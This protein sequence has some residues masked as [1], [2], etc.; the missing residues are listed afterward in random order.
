[1]GRKKPNKFFVSALARMR[2]FG[3][4]IAAF[5][6]IFLSYA[7]WAASPGAPGDLYVSGGQAN[8]ILQFDGIT[9]ASAGTFVPAGSGGMGTPVGVAWGPNGNLFVSSYNNDA[10]LQF[11]GN[12]GVFIN[13][14]ATG[15]GLDGPY[16]LTFGPDGNLY[17]CSFLNAR[18]VKFNGTTGAALGAFAT[19]GTLNFPAD[20]T[21]GPNGHLFVTS[22]TN[23]RVIQFDGTS[24]AVIGTFASG[25]G[26][27]SATG[28]TFGP[29]GNLFVASYNNDQVIQYDGATGAV[30]GS[31]AS[32]GGLDGTFGIEFG[33]D[34]N[35]YVAGYLSNNVV[36]YNGG[37]GALMG[38]F[39]TGVGKASFVKFKPI[40][41]GFPSP[42]VT[43]F[44]PASSM[45]CADI[46]ATIDGSG[47][48]TGLQVLL[49][50]AGQP[51]I[52][53]SIVTLSPT[54]VTANFNL[55]GVAL[56]SW[57]VETRYPDEQSDTLAAALDVTQCPP[58]SVTDF[59]P[60]LANNC[61]PLIGVTIIGNEFLT[62]ATVKLSRSGQSDIIGTSVVVQDQY[63]ITA[64]FN[65]TGAA[66][67]SWNLS[68]TNPAQTPSTLADALEII[69]CPPPVVSGI[70]PNSTG[71]C[72]VLNGATINGSNFLAGATVKLSMVGQSDIN[73]TGV[74]IGG[75]GTTIMANFAITG[76]APGLWDVAV[77]NPGLSGIGTLP[78]GLSILACP[79]PTVTGISPNT[80]TN[81]GTLS[82]A[83]ISGNNFQAGST[84][85]LVR[86]GQADIVGSSVTVQSQTS[87]QANINLNAVATGAWDVVVTR[88]DTMS[89]AAPMA[90]N[91]TGCPPG[92]TTANPSNLC[93]G[94]PSSFVLIAGSG[95]VRGLSV[96]LTHAGEADIPGAIHNQVQ[97]PIQ[98]TSFK[99]LFDLT[100]AVLGA[101][102]LVVT[103]PDGATFTKLN[104]VTVAECGKVNDVF[105]LAHSLEYSDLGLLFEYGADFQSRAIFRS[106]LYPPYEGLAI[107]PRAPWDQRFLFADFGGPNNNLFVLARSIQAVLE[108]DGITGKL[109]RTI[110]LRRA[111]CAAISPDGYLFVQGASS[112]SQLLFQR[113][114]MG[115]G[116]VTSTELDGAAAI[117]TRMSFD[118]S[119]RLFVLSPV[120]GLLEVDPANLHI[121][122]TLAP[123]ADV[124][125][126]NMGAIAI[127]PSTGR[128]LVGV[129]AVISGQSKGGVVEFD[130]NTGL[131]LGEFVST[132]GSVLTYSPN[133]LAFSP[134][135]NLLVLTGSHSNPVIEYDGATGELVAVR[136]S[137]M[138]YPATELGAMTIKPDLG[139][140]PSPQ[141]SG[142]ST[143]AV[144]NCGWN[145][146]IT[147][148]GS[149]MQPGLRFKLEQAGQKP[150]AIHI[151]SFSGNTSA[152]VRVFLGDAAP[153]FWDLRAR[154]P[155]GQSD[156][157]PGAVSISP[158]GGLTLSSLSISQ[159]DN[160]NPIFGAT[161]TG[162]G[163]DEGATFKLS[164]AGFPDLRCDAP[165]HPSR[166]CGDDSTTQRSVDLY[167]S[168]A[169][170]GD[171]DLVATN[172]WGQR[173]TLASALTIV[174]CA[175]D[176]T[177]QPL[178]N[179]GTDSGAYALNDHGAVTGWNKV[180]EAPGLWYLRAFKWQDGQF[181]DPN[182]GS[183]ES[184]IELGNG[185]SNDGVIVGVGPTSLITQPWDRAM[186][187]TPDGS[188]LQMPLVEGCSTSTSEAHAISKNGQFVAGQGHPYTCL[189]L[190]SPMIWSLE[191]GTVS[192][193][194][195]PPFGDNEGRGLAVNNLGTELMTVG[196][197]SGS[198]IFRST[199]LRQIDGTVTEVRSNQIGTTSYVWGTDVN[200]AG[201][202]VGELFGCPSSYAFW[203]QDGTY[204]R[205]E[206]GKANAINDKGYAVGTDYDCNEAYWFSVV[207]NGQINL[208]ENYLPNDIAHLVIPGWGIWTLNGAADINEKGWI[209]GT[210]T[211]NMDLS[212]GWDGWTGLP[213]VTVY[214]WLLT[215]NKK[216]D[217][218]LDDE[219]NGLDVQ[220]FVDVLLGTDSDP[221]QVFR[222]DMDRTGSVDSEDVFI[223]V[224][225]LVGNPQFGG[226]CTD[227]TQCVES[228]L[229]DCLMVGG[230]WAGNGVSCNEAS[231]FGGYE[232]T[233]NLVSYYQPGGPA[234]R[235]ADDLTLSG[236]F[237][238]L[239][240]I[241][242]AVFG[243]GVNQP[244][245]VTVQLY[246]GCPGDGGQPIPNARYQW[247]QIPDN[248]YYYLLEADPLNP[249]VTIPDTVWMEAEFST[250]SAGWV[251]ADQAEVGNTEDRVAVGNPWNCNQDFAPDAYAG[252]WAV[253]HCSSGERVAG[254]P[255]NSRGPALIDAA[256]GARMLRED[257]AAA[258]RI[259]KV[260]PMNEIKPLVRRKR[261]GA[262]EAR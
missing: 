173:A 208:S 31:F 156:V 222:A 35:L 55:A 37:T 110:P 217:L 127:H 6:P 33:T 19:G 4:I 18:V 126:R 116:E 105:I 124:Q 11:D 91:V 76:V 52:A 260:E 115:T 151:D 247:F 213:V 220:P 146:G 53:G 221:G 169:A 3:N 171:W 82:Q 122:R 252:L 255:S 144:D 253:L 98:W 232:N 103:N 109:A 190:S 74:V 78:G 2:W 25:G 65:I 133:Y 51:D 106:V 195:D 239:F 245:D 62:G 32:G 219:L 237:R 134:N 108:Y 130:L 191:N 176:F 256:T 93:Q 249:R 155:D 233:I 54:Q 167:V 226:C 193:V 39:A 154:Y 22:N 199:Y 92:I 142:I 164:R 210:S 36:R 200:D 114:D 140:Y 12:T 161:V 198:G 181:S 117:A 66:P 209:C 71:N 17:V 94:N 183:T 42:D 163:L 118:A 14:F 242:I 166:C 248:G 225:E 9:G 69:A 186:I 139:P 224:D 218:S 197:G 158:C 177:F 8:V 79:L 251:I 261:V 101:W 15:G 259:L 196:G 149:G 104:A 95:F 68:V 206:P 174:G 137:S 58:S 145:T 87:I 86:A 246:D 10:V 201:I 235:V 80:A 202:A 61:E 223:L 138:P 188:I 120:S 1:M 45:N 67:G 187:S 205:L 172:H 60:G 113:I 88:P 111:Y 20:V 238:D 49:K 107:L 228:S 170:P 24:G 89:A 16:G 212:F 70:N 100:H 97:D 129:D 184:R 23:S 240:S 38:A 152:T 75:G 41:G 230:T 257:N 131:E 258:M 56:G 250:N 236:A 132:V 40:L 165:E 50:Q 234:R 72:Y 185:I 27:S 83:I 231:C 125:A 46:Q 143:P 96:K 244:F 102:N 243:G 57:D 13:T 21:F 81:C 262:S 26:L 214:S 59:Q 43:G 48:A 123:I 194:D 28:L 254:L 147:I 84:V 112:G 136:I 159:T 121:I 128:L 204:F 215:P 85:K 207:P 63:T 203:F 227:V 175:K 157:M 153:G 241:E 47:F 211:M 119:G 216:G 160:C 90:L 7:V 192:V 148:T 168:S 73:G 99:A 5:M 229:L 189:P 179:R 180:S 141:L 44:A 29:N 30:I 150:V 135:G 64:N 34:G 162:T 178:G 77:T 182:F